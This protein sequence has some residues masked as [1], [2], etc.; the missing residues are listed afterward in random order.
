MNMPEVVAGLVLLLAYWS[1]TENRFLLAVLFSFLGVLTPG[2][3]NFCTN[4]NGRYYILNRNHRNYI[5][6]LIGGTAGLFLWSAWSYYNTGNWIF[7]L[8]SRDSG[9]AWDSNYQNGSRILSAVMPFI[10]FL[11]A[12]P[13][14][15]LINVKSAWAHYR[16]LAI[17]VLSYFTF[18]FFLQFR[19]FS[20]PDARYFVTI[21]PLCSL[22]LAFS[23]NK[24]W[25]SSHLKRALSTSLMITFLIGELIFFYFKSF[26]YTRFIKPA[27]Y[28]RQE[29]IQGNFCL[30]SQ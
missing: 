29:Q 5:S 9:L 21:L 8:I 16:F 24:H 19:Y 17:C 3:S 14:L 10:S 27:E 4:Y 22:A 25:S 12:F 15:F 20:Y 1:L 7:W 2:R 30:I 26:T 23:Y 28:I 11:I 6:L 18:I 13:T